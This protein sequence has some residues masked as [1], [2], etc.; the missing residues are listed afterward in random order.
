[1]GP[2]LWMIEILHVFFTK[3]MGSF[4]LTVGFGS[5]VCIGS[6]DVYHQPQVPITRFGLLQDPVEASAILGRVI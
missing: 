4:F 2:A 3:T 1:M 6:Q 5:T